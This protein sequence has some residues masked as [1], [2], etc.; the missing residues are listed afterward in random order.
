MEKKHRMIY[1]L[2]IVSTLAILC[3]VAFFYIK[4][5]NNTISDNT[6]SSVSEIAEHDKAAIESY[7]ETCWEDL[8][9]IHERFLSHD[10]KTIKD[11]KKRIILESTSSRFSHIYLL[12]QDGTV[13]T[14]QYAVY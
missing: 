1:L 4:Q 11:V 10:C 7:I 5:L 2:L 8:G 6:T 12:A 13:Y 9:H 3:A 14:D